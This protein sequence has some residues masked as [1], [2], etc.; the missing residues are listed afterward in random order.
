MVE[1]SSRG[2]KILEEEVESSK[3]PEVVHGM[4]QLLR[5]LE[6]GMMGTGAAARIVEFA[7]HKSVLTIIWVVAG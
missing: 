1:D 3:M 6:F 5:E 4:A 2:K 7:I